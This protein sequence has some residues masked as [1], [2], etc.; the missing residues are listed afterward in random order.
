MIYEERVRTEI[1]KGQRGMHGGAL[2]R[3]SVPVALVS[4]AC[5]APMGS[6][7][8]PDVSAR[9]ESD[10]IRGGEV[11]QVLIDP[12]L[13]THWELIADPAHP[14][15]PRRLVLLDP[16]VPGKIRR[17]EQVGE[18]PS[19]SLEGTFKGNRP[20]ESRNGLPNLVPEMAIRAGDRVAVDQE[21]EFLRAQ[22]QA[23][24]LESAGVGQR[25]RVRLDGGRSSQTGSDGSVI[26]VISTGAG[27][28]KW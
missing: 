23:V 13:G 7:M 25:L 14:D 19:G 26:T 8:R 2:L 5:G 21:T 11:I 17:G 20:Q 3:C 27:R 10:V 6:C 18:V 15:W 16:D 1:E 4:L 28:A 9:I 12:C 22:F 24:A